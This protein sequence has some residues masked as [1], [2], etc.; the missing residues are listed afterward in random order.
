MRVTPLADKAFMDDKLRKTCDTKYGCSL[1]LPISMFPDTFKEIN[2]SSL[3]VYCIEERIEKFQKQMLQ[4]ETA[5]ER[6]KFE[7]IVNKWKKASEYKAVKKCSKAY[8]CGKV[9]PLEM[10]L[11]GKT[12]NSGMIC[13]E[14]LTKDAKHITHV[15]AMKVSTVKQDVIYT[16]PT[17]SNKWIARLKYSH[18]MDFA[19]YL[20]VLE[21]QDYSCKICKTS[22]NVDAA[23]NSFS[24][25]LIDTDGS[26]Q[27]KGLLCKH[28]KTLVDSFNHD[29][30]LLASVVPYLKSRVVLHNDDP[31]CVSCI[32]ITH[33]IRHVILSSAYKNWQ[34]SLQ[35]YSGIT[36]ENYLHILDSQNKCCALCKKDE[37]DCGYSGQ[38][39]VMIPELDTVRSLI[40]DVDLVGRVRGLLCRECNWGVK[41][42]K[43]DA[44]V[45]AAAV[46]YLL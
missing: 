15:E 8:G 32:L 24:N 36:V 45:L 2:G 4:A 11:D 44:D 39:P 23:A 33:K 35:R 41:A 31:N 38:T 37:K 7:I 29:S 3:C 34:K 16:K 46:A 40:V 42:C 5:E 43:N 21:K 26:G 30:E 12:K 18:K 17:V 25:L 13:L 14:C 1:T 20:N 9:K 19:T 28:C 10:F 6:N 22:Y 27:V